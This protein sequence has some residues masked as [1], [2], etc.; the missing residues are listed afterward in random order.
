M[1]PTS[2]D[3]LRHTYMSRFLF[4]VAP[5]ELYWKEATLEELHRYL[6]TDLTSL[7]KDGRC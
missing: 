4:T 5:A 7:L 2:E 1:V 3:H 6:C